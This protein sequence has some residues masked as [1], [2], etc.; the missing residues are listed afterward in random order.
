MINSVIV[1]LIFVLSVAVMC[2][3]KPNAE[4]L[5]IGLFF[6]VMAIA[7]NMIIALTN[8]QSYVDMRRLNVCKYHIMLKLYG[9]LNPVI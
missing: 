4:R 6:L 5:F 7:V 2:L 3:V 9:I 8:P 1:W